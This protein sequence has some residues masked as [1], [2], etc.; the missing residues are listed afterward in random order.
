VFLGG[1]RHYPVERTLLT[2]GAVS[3]L[4]ESRYQGQKRIETPMLKIAYRAPK[5]SYYAHGEGS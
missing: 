4:M 3:F 2:T 1:K 5:K